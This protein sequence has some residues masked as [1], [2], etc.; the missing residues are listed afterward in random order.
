MNIF[1]VILGVATGIYIFAQ[2]LREAA[3]DVS[4]ER[5]G[6]EACARQQPPEHSAPPRT[7]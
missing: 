6:T 1:A 5:G 7:T 4:K 3:V 2:P